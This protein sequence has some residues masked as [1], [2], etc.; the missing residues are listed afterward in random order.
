[1]LQEVLIHIDGS[2]GSIARAGAVRDFVAARGGL[3]RGLTVA[4]IPMAPYGP[5]AENMATIYQGATDAIEAQARAI[6]DRARN[7]LGIEVETLS[8][9][10]SR[11]PI[12]CASLFR[13]FDF[14]AAAAPFDKTTYTDDDV[15]DA[16]LFLSGRPMLIMPRIAAAPM[17]RNIVIAW[18]DCREAARAVHEA[19]PILQKAEAVRLLAISGEEDERFFG[20]AALDRMVS[21]LKM[22][23]VPVQQTIVRSG[24]GGAGATF[25]RESGDADLIVMGGYGRWSIAERMFGGFT[26]L[27]LEKTRVPLFMAH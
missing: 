4:P 26:R 25:L 1:M 20:Q 24:Q 15:F 12:D 27:A 13:S 6:A 19:L 9:A 21:A 10:S 16:A 2:D 22:R 8:T 18:K 7:E 23:S 11:V 17:G 3:C 5:G 14:V